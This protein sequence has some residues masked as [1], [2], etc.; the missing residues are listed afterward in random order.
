MITLGCPPED[1]SQDYYIS[2]G[3]PELNLHLPRLHPGRETNPTHGENSIAFSSKASGSTTARA[4]NQP[5][6]A[7]M[8][9]P[10]RRPRFTLEEIIGINRLVGLGWMDIAWKFTLSYVQYETIIKYN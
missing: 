1:A 8:R 5:T 9:A 3:D 6:T 2:V 4:R 7:P 10:Q